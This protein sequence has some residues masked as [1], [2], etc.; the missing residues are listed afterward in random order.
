MVE[1]LLVYVRVD[2]LVLLIVLEDVAV[3]VHEVHHGGVEAVRAQEL[4]HEV[5][6]PICTN[7]K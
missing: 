3:L 6:D 1:E 4:Q 7:I 5:E 2:E